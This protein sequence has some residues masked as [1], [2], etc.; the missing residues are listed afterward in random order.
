M[1][2]S[3]SESDFSSDEENDNLFLLDNNSLNLTNLTN[4]TNTNLYTHELFKFLNTDEIIINGQILT[5]VIYNIN[6]HSSYPFIQFLLEKKINNLSFPII[7][8]TKLPLKQHVSA[9]FNLDVVALKYKGSILFNDKTFVFINYINESIIS[10]IENKYWFCVADEILNHKKAFN[11]PIH[12]LVTDFL[13][14]N[15]EYFL[16]KQPSNPDFFEIPVIVYTGSS[17]SQSKKNVMYKPDKQSVYSLFGPYFYFFTYEKAIEYAK[18]TNDSEPAGITRYCVFTLHTNT[19]FKPQLYYK[20]EEYNSLYIGKFQVN[21][22]IMN[23]SPV[24]IIK[25]ST[26]IHPLSSHLLENV[27]CSS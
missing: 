18:Q 13:L 8:L 23:D 1:D 10:P 22:H 11:I 25:N 20:M 17:Y 16:L 7:K 26:Q 2:T 27:P 3:T 15:P 19:I 6:S 12:K 24:W 9:C 21:T 14:A 4:L 5:I